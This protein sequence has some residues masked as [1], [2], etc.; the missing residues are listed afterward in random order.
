MTCSFCKLAKFGG[1]DIASFHFGAIHL[2]ELPAQK[3]LP[4]YD[5]CGRTWE[6]NDRYV[7][8]LGY[9][10]VVSWGFT[11]CISA[12]GRLIRT[13]RDHGNEANSW[14]ETGYILVHGQSQQ[15]HLDPPPRRYCPIFRSQQSQVNYFSVSYLFWSEAGRFYRKPLSNK[16]DGKITFRK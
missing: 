3:V 8:Y 12:L 15:A 4:V 9:I 11:S 14:D 13:A 7:Y 5:D 16:P 6:S 2:M 10:L 1:E